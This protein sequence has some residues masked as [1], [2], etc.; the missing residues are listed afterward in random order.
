MFYG[1]N[2]ANMTLY[3]K[4]AMLWDTVYILIPLQS[5]VDVDPVDSV[6]PVRHAWQLV[7]PGVSA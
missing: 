7:D 2:T 6:D 5:E 3:N 1:I 4:T